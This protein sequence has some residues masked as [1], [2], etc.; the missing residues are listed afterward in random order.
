MGKQSDLIKET[1]EILNQYHIGETVSLEDEKFLR[2]LLNSHPHAQQ[3]IG[4]GIL[5][6]TVEMDSLWKRSK[7]FSIVRIDG[8]STDFS[9]LKCITRPKNNLSVF[10]QAARSAI[11]DQITDWK[12]SQWLA[13]TEVSCS[14]CGKQLEFRSCHVD[15]Y[16][17]RFNKLI[18]NFIQ[19][20]D[21]DILSVAYVDPKDNDLGRSFKDLEFSH[22]FAQFH[23]ANMTLRL[24][25]S[26]CN[27][28]QP[29]T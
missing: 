27:L 15:H 24:T 19:F 21:I 22:S 25:C 5:Y 16:P 28:T 3:K 10:C 1:R 23:S 4:P 18:Q 11:S 8:T 20:Y 7:H 12:R 6:F 29:K 9:Y 17:L 13:N 2:D 26:H 14:I